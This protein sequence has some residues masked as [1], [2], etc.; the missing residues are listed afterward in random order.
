MPINS[1]ITQIFKEVKDSSYIVRLLD[2]I[3][4]TKYDRTEFTVGTNKAIPLITGVLKNTKTNQHYY[5]LAQFYNSVSDNHAT[6]NDLEMLKNIYVTKKYTLWRVL[7]NITDE[8]VLG[9]FDQKYR[10]FLL[11]RRVG[12]IIKESDL[13][14]SDGI[15]PICWNEQEY[16]LYPNRVVC[17]Y[18][19]DNTKI[20]ELLEA[21]E[22]D[23]LSE[24]NYLYNKDT[25]YLL[26]GI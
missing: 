4:N 8:C 14:Y 21:Y 3:V 24:L 20:F 15:I 22:G 25:N 26:Q 13:T 2:Y 19:Q 9:F 11:Y 17:K 18:T 7:C 23:K 12:K 16:E 10:S 6:E 5:S 1:T